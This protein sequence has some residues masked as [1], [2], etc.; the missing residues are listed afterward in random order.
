[1]ARSRLSCRVLALVFIGMAVVSPTRAVDDDFKVIVHRTNPINHVDRD[2]LRTAFLKTSIT[3]RHDGEPLRPVDLAR[4]N[5]IRERFTTE[6]LKKS[7][8]QLRNYWVQR[9]FSGTA[10]PPPE[11]DSPAAAVA[12]VAAN[13]GAVAYLPSSADPGSAKVVEIH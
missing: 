10:V 9:I 4:G 7:P 8:A 2:F 13:P 3:W 12:Y 11:V 6:V 1:V 5:P